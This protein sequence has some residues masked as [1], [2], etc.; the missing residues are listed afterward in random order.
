MVNAL[1]PGSY[2]PP[3][4]GH[5]NLIER[6][7][8]IFDS[9]SVVVAINPSKQYMFS[10]DERC[11]MMNNLVSHL[12]NITVI[13]WEGLIV[14]CAQKM[15]AR[16]MV[17]GV[18]ALGDFNYEFELSILNRG[19]D[20]EIETIFIPTDSKYLVLRSSSIKELVRFGGDI[21]KMVPV[22]VAEAL[23]EKILGK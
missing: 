12:P 10:A 22:S 17:R 11:A 21:S 13:P 8:R 9:I 14:E 1:I 7:S 3:T 16:V 6:A 4:Y 20:E 18:R 23:K 19:L 15:N 2:D 5:I